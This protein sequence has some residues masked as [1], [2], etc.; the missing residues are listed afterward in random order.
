[1]LC[2]YAKVICIDEVVD[3]YTVWLGIIVDVK[4]E[5]SQHTPLWEAPL[6]STP[7]AFLTSWHHQKMFVLQLSISSVRLVSLVV[8]RILL[9]RPLWLTVS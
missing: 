1:M 7:S 8:S 6:E 4:K 9:R 3:F 5:W 2:S